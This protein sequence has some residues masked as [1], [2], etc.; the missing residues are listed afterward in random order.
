MRPT[1]QL[2]ESFQ[3]PTRMAKSD[4]WPSTPTHYRVP[5]RIMI[6]TTR[7]SWQYSKHSNPGDT[8]WKDQPQPLTQ[9]QTIRTCSTSPPPKSLPDNKP[10][11]LNSY[12]SST[13]RS[14]S[15]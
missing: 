6:C 5:S 13:L 7:N 8:F 11:C 4:Q 10:G 1:A 12:H 15:D 2:R 3:G 9:Q 14:A